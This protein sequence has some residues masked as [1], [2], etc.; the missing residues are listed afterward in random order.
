V[1]DKGTRDGLRDGMTVLDQNGYFVGSIS[2]VTSNTATVL[3]LDNPSSS[4]GAE[5][6]T[7]HA[8]GVVWGNINGP[9]Q[10]RDVVTAEKLKAG[11]LVVTSGQMNLYPRNLLIGQITHVSKRTIQTFQ[12]VDIRPAA[13]IAHLE[14]VQVVRNWIPT[15]SAQMVPSS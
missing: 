11:D 7:T 1:I 12:T 6:F 15:V 4:V 9:P 8:A 3:L 10:L 5:D 2:H 13:D 14:I